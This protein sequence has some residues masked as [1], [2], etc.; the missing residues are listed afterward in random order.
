M[1]AQTAQ[2]RFTSGRTYEGTGKIQAQADGVTEIA[3][4]STAKN[5]RRT[6]GTSCFA[7]APRILATNPPC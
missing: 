5:G 1:D 7:E 2:S 6:R 3:R 4:L